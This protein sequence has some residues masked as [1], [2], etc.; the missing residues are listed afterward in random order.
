MKEASHTFGSVNVVVA[1]SNG[2]LAGLD[3]C[4]VKVAFGR[5]VPCC[6]QAIAKQSGGQLEQ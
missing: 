3:E 6:A 4:S 1:H 5:L 2:G